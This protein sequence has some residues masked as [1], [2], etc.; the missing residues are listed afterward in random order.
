MIIG[1]KK[2]GPGFESEPEVNNRNPSVKIQICILLAG[3]VLDVH[4]LQ[5]W[6]THKGTVS[7]FIRVGGLS[8]IFVFVFLRIF[9]DGK[10]S[11]FVR[12]FSSQLRPLLAFHCATLDSPI[13]AMMA[14]TSQDSGKAIQTVMRH[15]RHLSWLIILFPDTSM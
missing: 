14:T 8:C 11:A 5:D 7:V 9:A 6:A 10:R 4:S 13:H 15:L 1:R 12:H 3:V 2:P